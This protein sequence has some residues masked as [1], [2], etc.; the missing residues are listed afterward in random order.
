MGQQGHERIHA[1]QTR[2]SALNGR[3]RLLSLGLQAQMGTAFLKGRL[4]RPAFDKSHHNV[5][6]QTAG[7]GRKVRPWCVRTFGVANQHPT[8]RQHGLADLVPYGSV[9]GHLQHPPAI[10]IPPHADTLP[11]GLC[12][13]EHLAGS[14]R[15]ASSR[16]GVIKRTPRRV[17]ALPSSSTL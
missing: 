13:A 9:T 14:Y 1:Q 6:S 8:Q 12:L 16:S 11:G 4:D 3:V 15:A 7:I 2:C 17:Q 10:V 5:T